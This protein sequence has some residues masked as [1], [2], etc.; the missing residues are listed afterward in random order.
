MYS[1]YSVFETLISKWVADVFAYNSVTATLKRWSNA[2]ICLEQESGGDHW[3]K[4]VA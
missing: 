4:F 2:I 1:I 3:P